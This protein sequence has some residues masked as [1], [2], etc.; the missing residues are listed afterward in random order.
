MGQAD[1]QSVDSAVRTSSLLYRS[2]ASFTRLVSSSR[3]FSE[4]NRSRLAYPANRAGDDENLVSN[5][6]H[7]VL[8]S[9]KTY[10]FVLLVARMITKYAARTD[11]IA[12]R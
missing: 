8:L 5:S 10:S 12:I 4:H 6:P 3:G 2:H 9:Q 11:T 1:G 7:E